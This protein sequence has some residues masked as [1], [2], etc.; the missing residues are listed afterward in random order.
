VNTR[1]SRAEEQL[2]AGGIS[3][4]IDEVPDLFT[5]LSFQRQVTLW[6]NVKM[7]KSV[8]AISE[9]LDKPKSTIQFDIEIWQEHK[10]IED[11]PG[12]GRAKKV[13]VQ[14][15]RKRQKIFI[16]RKWP[17]YAFPSKMYKSVLQI[18][19]LILSAF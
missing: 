2:L 4:V 19:C 7:K 17:F 18:K 16:W 9:I 6:L 1:F 14:I 3:S 10:T 11:I 8:R 5:D 12:R 13:K 15:G